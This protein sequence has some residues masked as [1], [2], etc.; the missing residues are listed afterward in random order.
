LLKDLNT[1]FIL[2]ALIILK[3]KIF[4]PNMNNS[5]INIGKR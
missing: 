5:E 2:T 1:R 4:L 3:V